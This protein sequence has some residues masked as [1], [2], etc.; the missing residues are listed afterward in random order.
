LLLALSTLPP[1]WADHH[2]ALYI[3]MWVA[4]IVCVIIATGLAVRH[5]PG[6]VS[7]RWKVR[8]A[9]HHPPTSTLEGHI[10]PDSATGSRDVMFTTDGQPR[11]HIRTTAQPVG[12][13]ITTPFE[14]TVGANSIP[15]PVRRYGKTIFRVIEFLPD[16][17][18]IADQSPGLTVRGEIS[19]A[20]LTS[21]TWVPQPETVPPGEPEDL[22]PPAHGR[23]DRPT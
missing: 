13:W 20:A 10:V 4:A 17:I 11:R 3:L 1:T 16:G 12:L 15:A 19:Y 5:V 9:A 7:I 2:H 6:W 21:V 18:V 23:S 14:A 22:C 8:Y